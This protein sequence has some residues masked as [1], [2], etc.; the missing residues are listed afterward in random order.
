MVQDY[1]L[2]QKIAIIFRI[3]ENFYL[4]AITY[5][6]KDWLLI[7]YN[8]HKFPNLQIIDLNFNRITDTGLISF[9]NN[10]GKLSALL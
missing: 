3:C 6:I 8:S 1:L 9:A 5:Q 2:F 10:S 7:A 4:A